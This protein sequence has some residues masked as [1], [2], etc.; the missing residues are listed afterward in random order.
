[1]KFEIVQMPTDQTE[2]QRTLEEYI[3]LL[4][5]MYVEH[6]REIFGE[7]NILLDHWLYLWDNGGGFFLTGRDDK[8]QLKVLAMLTRFK[9]M[10]HSRDR[11][12]IHRLAFADEDLITEENVNLIIDYLKS[13]A[14]IMRFDLL[15]MCLKHTSG[16]EIK[17]LI[18]NARGS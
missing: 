16:A 13:M 4:D 5:S 9:D 18:W 3:P 11:L 12:D 10:W 8:G 7:P 14:S 2:L 15:F 17:E 1:M 6:E